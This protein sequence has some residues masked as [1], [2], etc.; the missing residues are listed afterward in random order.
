IPE[1]VLFLYDTVPLGSDI[2]KSLHP[3]DDELS[4]A[5]VKRIEIIRGP[6]SVLWGPDA[7][8][9]IVNVVP[10]TGKDLNGAETGASASHSSSGDRRG[11]FLNLGHDAGPWNALLSVSGSEETENSTCT[12]VRFWGDGNAPP[13]APEDRYGMEEPGTSRYAQASGNFSLGDWFTLSGV[14]SDYKRP[15]AMSAI[16]EKNEELTWRESRRAPFGF[17]KM[18]AKKD[19]DRSSALRFTGSYSWI[20]PE[21][22]TIDITFKQRERT[23]Y[24]EIIYD[25]SFLA[26]R[27]L[28]TGGASYRKKDIHDAP[29]W[30][31]YLPDY[32]GSDNETFLPRISEEDYNTRLLSLFCQ[33][34]HKIGNVDLW[35]GLRN[36][37]HDE[38]KDHLSYNAGAVWSFNSQWVLKLL[39][40]TAYRTPFAKQLLDEEKPELEKIKTLNA[41]IAW[42]PSKRVGLSLCGFASWIDDHMMEDPYAGL[43]RPNSQDILGLEFQGRLSPVDSLDLSANLTLVDNSGP[44][45]TYHYLDHVEGGPPPKPWIFIYENLNYPY[46]AG[47]Q[48]IFNLMGTWRPFGKATIYAKIGY[49]SSRDLIYPRSGAVVSVPGVWLADVCATVLDMA[50]S[51]LELELSVRNLMDRNYETPG[52]YDLIK[53]DPATV[54]VTLRK[55]W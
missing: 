47:P 52:T 17:I 29:I 12:L 22:E 26:G 34:D 40:G 36:D 6:G 1:S 25:R 49:F 50:R 21:Y 18:E 42:N 24:G 4:L 45:E 20:N 35:V 51:G 8:A 37:D 7:F 19:L 9:G 44:D 23:T 3:L 43:S 46:D 31:S 33:Y 11:F 39:Y 15:Y 32:L 10:M 28:F 48:T 41:Q 30:D 2:S 13:V 53:G 16:T 54:S 27:S 38:Y 5:T 14:V 55:R